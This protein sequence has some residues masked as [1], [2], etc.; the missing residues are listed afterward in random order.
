MKVSDIMQRQVD[1]VSANTSVKD[2]S[3]LIFG[4]S[5]N[6]VPVCDGKKLVG[7]ITERD[8]L[9]KFYPSMQEYVEDTV[10]SSDFEGMEDKISEIFQLTAKDIMSKAP[11]TVTPETPLLRAQSLMFIHKVGR[12]PV[13]DAKE[14][15]VGILSK[16]DIFR[17][18][19]GEKLPFDEE[20]KFFDWLSIHYDSII[21]WKKRLSGEV[22]DLIKILKREKALNIVDVASSTGEHA[23]ELAKRG[24]NAFGIEVSAL[25]HQNAQAKREK[26]PQSVKNNIEF[27]VGEY[28][29]ILNKHLYKFDAALF[30][31]NAL[32]HVM[33]TEIDILKYTSKALNSKKS[34]LIFQ[35]IN[36]EKIIKERSGLVDF[37]VLEGK[38]SFRR[39]HAFLRF[40]STFPHNNKELLYNVASLELEDK[41]WVFRG[42][43]SKSAIYIGKKEIAEMLKKI[44]Y[45]HV[46]YYGGKFYG[47]LFKEP[48]KPL[49]SD[50]LNIVAKR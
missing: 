3:L 22:P 8:I 26:L 7:F 14:N 1:Y 38:S 35:I 41:K 16:G 19:V 23:I 44:G 5:I 9:S 45:H 4:K 40:Y 33:D 47:P 27:L 18:I 50:W 31:G 32:C 34:I 36:F 12:L 37:T 17:A 48:F 29:D 21:D 30:M 49:E 11:T 43:R 2:I 20:G 13:V 46:E 10:H 15:L 28:K 42:I 39:K 24:F 25:M 6:G